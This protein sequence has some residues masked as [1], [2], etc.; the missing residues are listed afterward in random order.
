LPF[1][2]NGLESSNV[3]PPELEK[4]LAGENPVSVLSRIKEYK[5]DTLTNF[6]L[7]QRG[8]SGGIAQVITKAILLETD[9]YFDVFNDGKGRRVTFRSQKESAENP[10]IE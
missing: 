5:I 3:T 2:W 4:V 1:E 9:G 6:G 8:G 10:V 7:R